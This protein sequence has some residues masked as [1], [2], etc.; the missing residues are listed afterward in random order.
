MKLIS[1]IAGFALRAVLFYSILFDTVN[2]TIWKINSCVYI[3]P[4]FQ[5]VLKCTV[6]YKDLLYMCTSKLFSQDKESFAIAFKMK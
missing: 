5:Y 1:S 2:V 3:Q 4:V 6:N